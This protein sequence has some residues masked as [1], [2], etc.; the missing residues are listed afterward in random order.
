MINIV[1]SNSSIFTKKKITTA[2][3][4]GSIMATVHRM[5][6]LVYSRLQRTRQPIKSHV[7]KSLLTNKEFNMDFTL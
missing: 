1:L 7:R 6:M 3:N 5:S 2:I 4:R